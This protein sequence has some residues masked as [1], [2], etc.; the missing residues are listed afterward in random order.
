MTD[1][2]TAA[3][4]SVEKDDSL[5]IGVKIGI[6]DGKKIAKEEGS[7]DTKRTEDK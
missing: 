3:N 2:N 6:E 7:K 1:N 4:K 5:E